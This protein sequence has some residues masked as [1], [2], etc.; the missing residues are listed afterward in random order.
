MPARGNNGGAATAAPEHKGYKFESLVKQLI[1]LKRDNFPSWRKLIKNMAY[2]LEWDPAWENMG[3]NPG[4]HWDGQEEDDH[5]ERRSRKEAFMAMS[6]S[7]PP[8]SEFHHLL[9][10]VRR[11]DANQIWRNVSN[12]FLPGDTANVGTMRTEFHTL[13]MAKTRMNVSN[14]AAMVTVKAEQLGIVGE[15]V[16][17]TDK[18][19]VL[20]D[21][22]SKHFATIVTLQRNNNDNYNLTHMKV[23]RFAKKE[24]LLEVRDKGV[25]AFGGGNFFT[26]PPGYKSQPRHQQKRPPQHRQGRRQPRAGSSHSG[27]QSGQNR[28]S[29]NTGPNR[30]KGNCYTA[31]EKQDI[32]HQ[33]ARSHQREIMNRNTMCRVPQCHTSW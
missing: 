28:R 31:V 32:L 1:I 9:S 6:A 33:G 25:P 29:Q 26:G 17:D 22:L 7:M 16:S 4:D 14:Y 15:Q 27:H 21:G 12:I 5:N 10:G 23:I 24:N 30:M 11:G 2:F 19:N 20:L 8:S 13:S 3:P 18:K